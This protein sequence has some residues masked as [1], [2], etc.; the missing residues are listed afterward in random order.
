[1]YLDPFEVV[2]KLQ[3]N[4]HSIPPF[5]FRTEPV[6]T[7]PNERVLHQVREAGRRRFGKPRAEVEASFQ[8]LDSPPPEYRETLDIDED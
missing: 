4:S 8:T 7:E 2:A 1:M 6:R 3:I 5:A